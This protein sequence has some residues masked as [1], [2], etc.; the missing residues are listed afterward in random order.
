MNIVK[1][2][3]WGEIHIFF[4]GQKVDMGQEMYKTYDRE[5]GR[6]RNKE[7]RRVTLR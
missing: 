6:Q 1:G 3:G 7:R 4:Y 2:E 5:Y